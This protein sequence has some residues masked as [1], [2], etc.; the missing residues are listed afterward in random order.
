MK[1]IQF[2]S[3]APY[4]VAALLI[5]ILACI[6]GMGTIVS[7]IIFAL[8]MVGIFLFLRKT[9]FPDWFISVDDLPKSKDPQI[10]QLIEECAEQIKQIRK[11]GRLI[12]EPALQSR[13]DS[14]LN[15]SVQLLHK[16]NEQPA[17]QGQLR[18][19]LRYY[20]PT[21]KKLLDIRVKLQ[22]TRLSPSN[23]KTR[24]KIDEALAMIEESCK[25]QLDA[26]EHTQ[27]L[28]VDTEIEVLRQLNIFPQDNQDENQP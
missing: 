5:F 10:N 22:D 9:V 4:V 8:L 16:L 18:T 7:Y 20:L 25:H 26:I 3:G 21:M 27:T 6:F 19:F 17:L 11:T 14:I 15:V 28:D 12:R 2:R 1:N 13:V 24:D 23:E